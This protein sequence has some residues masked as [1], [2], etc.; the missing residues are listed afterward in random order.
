MRWKL[1]AGLAV[2][3]S[4][5]WFAASDRRAAV[6]ALLTPSAQHVHGR[7]RFGALIPGRGTLGLRGVVLGP[8]GPVAGA[9]VLAA[10]G[11]AALPARAPRERHGSTVVNDA[12]A[13]SAALP[14]EAEDAPVASAESGVEGAFVL[15]GLEPGRLNLWAEHETEGVAVREG[16]EAGTADL[17]LRLLPGRTLR[18]R[19]TDVFRA[20]IVSA[21]ISAVRRGAGK[22]YE[23]TTDAQGAYELRALPDGDYVLVAADEVHL[24]AQRDAELGTETNDFTLEDPRRLVVRARVEGALVEGA[25]I[26]AE[27]GGVTQ[28]GVTDASGAVAFEGLAEGWCDVVARL[29]DRVGLGKLKLERRR[30]I[31]A[32]DVALE[33]S[34]LLEGTVRDELGAAIPGANVVLSAAHVVMETDAAGHFEVQLPRRLWAVCVSARGYIRAPCQDVA[35]GGGPHDVVLTR[36]AGIEGMVVDASGA[37]VAE[38]DVVA[39]EPK[40]SWGRSDAGGHFR[41]EV[42]PGTWEIGV[43]HPDFL[44]EFAEVQAP[45][46]QVRLVL[47]R[48]A[49]VV[50]SVLNADGTPLAGALVATR[51]RRTVADSGGHFRLSGLAEGPVS[52]GAR[53]E[54]PEGVVAVDEDVTVSAGRPTELVLRIPPSQQIEGTVVDQRQRPVVDILVLAEPA[55]SG[56]LR[57]LTDAR[58]AFTLRGPRAERYR[59]SVEVN[60]GA[61]CDDLMVQPGARGVVIRCELAP[62]VRGR[63]LDGALQPL[64]RFEIGGRPLVSTDGVFHRSLSLSTTAL[65]ISAEHFAPRTVA[66]HPVPGEE[67]DLGDV[68]L[69]AGRT[70]TVKL[71]D[72]DLGTPVRGASI[73]AG[74]SEDPVATSDAQGLFA[75]QNVGAEPI[76][77][78]VRH[79][80]YG[81]VLVKLPDEGDPTVVRLRPRGAIDGRLLDAHGQGIQG[82]L[83]ISGEVGA[84]HHPDRLQSD[85][86]GHFRVHLSPGAYLLRPYVDLPFDPKR[87]V[88]P[89]EGCVAV[90]LR[91]R[92]GATVWIK[93]GWPG[94]E[95]MVLE[96]GTVEWD[97]LDLPAAFDQ[98]SSDRQTPGPDGWAFAA[99]PPGTY[100][101]LVFGFVED[102]AYAAAI[103][104]IVVTEAPLQN[105]SLALEPKDLRVLPLR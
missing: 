21:K 76:S 73:D 52:I 45:A 24:P 77:L 91:P 57:A 83:E 9:T 82:V 65:T 54:G 55:E 70:R 99:V 81:S 15:E 53:L 37:P 16:V 12:R 93:S 74:L 6:T 101:V 42:A 8:N 50:G 60:Q 67:I 20:P 13:L 102:H 63:V 69:D 39:T 29:K 46:T 18:G 1:W 75:L 5:F 61:S 28:R 51:D 23:T 2:L 49:E 47:R 3:L 86:T 71:V 79:A 78:T 68:V 56:L 84:E 36:S 104:T 95:R 33:A 58:G 30:M 38:A 92:A 88:V 31:T 4:A 41:L 96:R 14:T 80:D 59:L 90:E 35:G 87:V 19:V 17:V 103:R 40:R 34:G 89:A 10:R 85:E 48:G 25:A 22:V 7:L 11:R 94:E 27:C 32:T 105:F 43:A 26:E 72:A 97:A 62:R 98:L 100:S 66:V 44:D 64:S